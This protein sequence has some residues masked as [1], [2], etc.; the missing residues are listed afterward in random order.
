[1]A[2]NFVGFFLFFGLFWNGILSSADDV[3]FHNPR[4]YMRVKDEDYGGRK[5]VTL[6]NGETIGTD[7]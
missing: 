3:D 1:M 7:Q 6:T 2:K 4:S 5:T